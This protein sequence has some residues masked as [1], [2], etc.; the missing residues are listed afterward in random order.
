MLL[1]EKGTLSK[2]EDKDQRLAKSRE[3]GTLEKMKDQDMEKIQEGEK[4]ETQKEIDAVH[5]M[6]ELDS[7]RDG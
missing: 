2:D 3:E 4:E 1:Q 5:T 7:S 6:Q